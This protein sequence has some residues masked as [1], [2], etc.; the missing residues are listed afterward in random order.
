MSRQQVFVV[1]IIHIQKFSGD[2]LENLILSVSSE[3]ALWVSYSSFVFHA[4]NLKTVQQ[5]STVMICF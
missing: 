5:N 4:L 2:F 1:D 3:T